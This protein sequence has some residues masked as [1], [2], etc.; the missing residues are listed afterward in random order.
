MS[1]LHSVCNAIN[2]GL[3]D[4]NQPWH[5]LFGWA[6]AKTGVGRFKLF[7]GFAFVVIMFLFSAPHGST[8]LLADLIG[9]AYPAYATIG[10]M[11]TTRNIASG[12]G[13]GSVVN[14]T[15]RLLTYWLMFATI[16]FI[17]QP[18]KA[19]TKLLPYY[20]LFKII[21]FVWCFAPIE[22]NGAAFVYATVIAR[23]F[24]NNDNRD[25]S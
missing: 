24:A 18:F 8:S 12:V 21:F 17:Q 22:T 9:F 23:Y 3:H 16:L 6:E 2:N 20:G 4:Q 7:F 19:V 13:V 11:L 14:D 1:A 10:T 15:V 5:I 25:D